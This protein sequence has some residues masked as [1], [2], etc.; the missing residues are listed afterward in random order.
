MSLSK[1]FAVLTT[2]LGKNI[3]AL[4]LF[5]KVSFFNPQYWIAQQND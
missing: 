5:A 2:N 1:Q 3:A 4:F